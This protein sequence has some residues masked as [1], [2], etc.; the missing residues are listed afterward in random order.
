MAPPKRNA[1][2]ELAIDCSDPKKIRPSEDIDHISQ[3][4]QNIEAT[5]K[6]R[7]S[8]ISLDSIKNLLVNCGKVLTDIK[9]K[10]AFEKSFQ[11]TERNRTFVIQN[12]PESIAKSASKRIN[13]DTYLES[14]LLDKLNVKAIPESVYK[15]PAE[16]N[17]KSDQ[18]SK[19][20]CETES[21]LE[22]LDLRKQGKNT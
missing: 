21:N 11:E 1:D 19:E 3:L 14:K 10:L 18:P 17:P 4:L 5:V 22:S 7:N 9:S 13:E 8:E 15:L 2:A 12:L 6:L 16:R 20:Q